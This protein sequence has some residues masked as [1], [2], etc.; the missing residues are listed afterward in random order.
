[1]SEEITK[2]LTADEKLDLLIAEMQRVNSRLAAIE[3]FV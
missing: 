3:A 1:M 2:D